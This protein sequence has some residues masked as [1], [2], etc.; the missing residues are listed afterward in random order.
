MGAITGGVSWWE[1][2][3]P[4]LVV[5]PVTGLILVFFVV[6]SVLA[7]LNIITGIFVNDAIEKARSDHELLVARE[8]E[9]NLDVRR[10]LKNVF[11]RLD[12][13]HRG[14]LSLNDFCEQMEDREVQAI[15]SLMGVEVTDAKAFFQL[16]DV[17]NTELVE[18]D[19]FVMGCMRF[20]SKSSQ[21]SMEC[22][23]LEIKKMTE[24]SL[25]LERITNENLAE[26][27]ART[28]VLVR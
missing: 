4:I 5:G 15:F 22:S 26:L 11:K 1:I 24:K 16:L 21:V 25:A 23:I 10:Q 9:Q 14:C 12:T 28:P 20:K 8:I 18:L 3:E 6:L 13:H 17:D 19:E 27:T 7:V 2:M